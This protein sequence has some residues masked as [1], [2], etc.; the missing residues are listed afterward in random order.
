MEYL[1]GECRLLVICSVYVFENRID[2]EYRIDKVYKWVHIS[3]FRFKT[4]FRVNMWFFRFQSSCVIRLVLSLQRIVGV[5]FVKSFV[6]KI[7]STCQNWNLSCFTSTVPNSECI[8]LLPIDSAV[9]GAYYYSS[10]MYEGQGMS[11]RRLW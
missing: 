11:L 2:K 3:L 6:R 7:L 1:Y 8:S 5:R 4:L 9:F 10:I